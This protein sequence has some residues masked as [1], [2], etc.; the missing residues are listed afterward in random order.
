MGGP[1]RVRALVDDGNLMIGCNH[2]SSGQPLRRRQSTH[3]RA[4]ASAGQRQQG[5]LDG[6]KAVTERAVE[7]QTIASRA[8]E[9]VLHLAGMVEVVYRCPRTTE[10]GESEVA[11]GSKGRSSAKDRVKLSQG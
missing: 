6:T 3:Q 4:A 10:R 7:T 9:R 5:R 11:S 2:H 8:A 1:E